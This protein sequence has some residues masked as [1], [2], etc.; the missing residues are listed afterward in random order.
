MTG[1]TAA[2]T[3][4]MS[5]FI[6]SLAGKS[7]ETVATYQKSLRR[8]SEFLADRCIPEQTPTSELPADVLEQ[9]YVWL[10]D[11][12]GR[13]ARSTVTTYVAGVRAFFRY[14]SRHRL[15]PTE[16]SFEQMRAGLLEVMGKG[17]YKTPR[18]DRR[19][20]MIVI[21]VN[22]LPLPEPSA[23][24]GRARRLEI[25]RDRAIILTLFTTGMRREEVSRLKRQDVEDGW[26]SQALITGKGD[27]ERIVFFTEGALESIRL[28]LKER[29]DRYAPL[30]IRHDNRR[31]EAS[32][33]GSNYQL[34]PRAIW[35]VVKQYSALA[36]VD[37]STHD[38]RHAKASTMLNRGAK[39]SE[40]QDIL[41]HASP[42][43]T[44]KIYAHYEVSH[45]RRA[46]DQYSATAE[47]LMADL[48]KARK[49]REEAGFE[50]PA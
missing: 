41:G 28:Y 39:L 14:L 40:V 30:F 19:L 13:E 10:V 6:Q 37:V 17:S 49:R 4:Q 21:Y 33:G 9:F 50:D 43:T 42:E 29:G 15:L 7:P 8:F 11:V 23:P 36:G 1:D 38:F 20:P 48:E 18:I 3:A 24:R 31:G 27:K 25:L 16:T 5:E 2:V 45:L 46:F 44:K 35:R 34:E 26:S 47:E 22:N 32:R 12:F